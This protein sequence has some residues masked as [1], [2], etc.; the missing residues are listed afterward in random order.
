MTLDEVGR[1]INLTNK[2]INKNTA[3]VYNNK[4]KVCATVKGQKDRI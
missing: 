3:K 2:R 4:R 1:Y